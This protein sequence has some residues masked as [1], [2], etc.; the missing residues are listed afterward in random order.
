MKRLLAIL[1]STVLLVALPGSA[2]AIVYGEVDTENRYPFVGLLAFYEGSGAYSHR[3]SGTLVSPTVVLTAAHCIYNHDFPGD[4]R[5]RE[6]ALDLVYD[7]RRDGYDPLQEFI[8]LHFLSIQAL[9]VADDE[10]FQIV[11]DWLPVETTMGRMTIGDC[12][13]QR[14]RARNCHRKP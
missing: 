11:A 9:A 13:H 12:R 10:F 7:R 1:G 2:G 6:V 5:A 3:C 4:E 8:G 14:R